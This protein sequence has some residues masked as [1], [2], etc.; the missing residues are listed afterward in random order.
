MQNISLISFADIIFKS[1]FVL[2]E[3]ILIFVIMVKHFSILYTCFLEETIFGFEF[4]LRFMSLF[5]RNRGV[6]IKVTGV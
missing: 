3:D 2:V 1:P 4:Y 6:Y 5:M